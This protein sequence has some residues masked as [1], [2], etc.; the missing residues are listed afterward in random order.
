MRLIFRLVLEGDNA[1]G[2]MGI[3]ALTSWLNA[4]G[5]RTRGGACW[6]VGQ[7]HGLLTNPVYAGR[8]RFNRVENKTRRVKPA[9]EHVYCDAPAII[10]SD[11]FERVQAQLKSRNPKVVAPRIVTGPILLTG[12][13]VCG[14]CG[15]GMT[16]RTGT[17]RTGTVYRYYTCMTQARSGKSACKGRSIRMDRLDGLV[18]RHLADKLL[19]PQRMAE[20]LSVLT[21]RRAEKAKVVDSRADALEREVADADQRLS[22]LYRLVE[23]GVAEPDGMLKARI[24]NLRA[25]REAASAALAPLKAGPCDGLRLTTDRIAQFSATMRERIMSGEV[26]FRKA[27]IGSIVDRIEV[28]DRE[29]RIHGRK[30]VLEQCVLGGA[31]PTG[32]VRSSVRGWLGD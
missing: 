7:V 20:M 10:E 15:G 32:V 1:S 28:D 9:S 25:G 16:L 14:T 11:V 22:R 31:K 8:L 3:K 2:P 5:Y 21:E 13:A 17:S 24:A 26:P 27:W 19:Q 18:T 6:G 23:E 30:D 12:L 4:R 29:I